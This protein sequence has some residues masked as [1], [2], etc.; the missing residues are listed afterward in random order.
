MITHVC[1]APV[2][3]PLS[4]LPF[5]CTSALSPEYGEYEGNEGGTVLG[6]SYEALE[7]GR[8]LAQHSMDHSFSHLPF[9]PLRYLSGAMLLRKGECMYPVPLK[10]V[11][12]YC[13]SN[14]VAVGNGL[15]P[16]CLLFK[17]A[18]NSGKGCRKPEWASEFHN[19]T[20]SLLD[21]NQVAPGPSW[22]LDKRKPAMLNYQLCITLRLWVIKSFTCPSTFCSGI[23]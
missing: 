14:E 4:L 3:H 5:V 23:F 22:N 18:A 19:P 17:R 1:W 15:L 2:H 13:W 8:A 11:P 21:W 9:F 16:P 12:Q 7:G 10:I 6:R 20:L